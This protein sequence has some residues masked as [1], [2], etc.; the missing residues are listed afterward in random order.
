MLQGVTTFTQYASP[1]MRVMR[2]AQAAHAHLNPE[3]EDTEGVS[4]HE[5]VGFLVGGVV[6]LYLTRWYWPRGGG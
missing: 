6:G 2:A 5:V 3:G 4:L 1:A